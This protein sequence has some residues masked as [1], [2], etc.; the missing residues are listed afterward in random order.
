M[1]CNRLR[2]MM[3]FCATLA[4]PRS[5]QQ[6]SCAEH[7]P[8]EPAHYVPAISVSSASILQEIKGEIRVRVSP[9]RSSLA[10]CTLVLSR[11]T[12]WIPQ[13]GTHMADLMRLYLTFGLTLNSELLYVCARFSVLAL[14]PQRARQRAPEFSHPST[15]GRQALIV[16]STAEFSVKVHS[17]ILRRNSQ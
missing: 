7:E 8:E 3:P 15:F 12:I 9:F 10:Q 11:C 13:N 5:D 6:I 14:C 4:R 2:G 16:C 1:T 17:K